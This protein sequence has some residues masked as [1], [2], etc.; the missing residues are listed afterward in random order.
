VSA[1]QQTATVALACAD[2]GV[3]L[4]P[5]A[6]ACLVCNRL[7]HADELNRMAT[8][9]DDAERGGHLESALGT[10]R[11]ALAKVPPGTRPHAAIVERISELELRVGARPRGAEPRS[12][13][14]GSV[15]IVAL[16]VALAGKAKFLLVGLT[17]AGPLVSLLASIGVSGAAYGWKVGSGLVLS[18]YLHELGH[19][20]AFRR[21]GI[22]A[23]APMFVP[24]FGAFVRGKVRPTDP[25]VDARI[26]LAGPRW[27][28][29]AALACLVVADV[30]GWPSWRAIA[31]LAALVNL[32]NLLPVWHLDG[33]HAFRALATNQR[34]YVV[35]AAAVGLFALGD[36]TLLALAFTA[37]YAAWRGQKPSN[38]PR[39]GLGDRGVF[40][41]IV[42]LVLVLSVIG[43]LAATGSHTA[44]S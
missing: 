18:I 37:A 42:L 39:R 23:S 6:L 43:K 4:A 15:G 17:K 14:A 16:A 25:G 3:Q 41:E 28:A 19:V 33:A 9:A 27:G 10:W 40:V 26:A 24:G 38:D 30:A 12:R 32:L 7:V 5:T 2:C 31:A 1:D 22:A 29:V 11:S 34:W 44:T 35:G 21:Y 8:A 13:R 36:R 20:A